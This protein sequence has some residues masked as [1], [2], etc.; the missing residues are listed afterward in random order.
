[1][2]NRYGNEYWFE[3]VEHNVYRV[4][5]DLKFWR[6]GGREGQSGIDLEDLGF[7]DPSG[8]PFI[9]TGYTIQDREHNRKVVKISAE[10]DP[11]DDNK[12][13]VLL[14]VE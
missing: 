6:F 5:G 14:T 8:G 9:S 11:I 4:C 1:M 13:I 12:A 10:I 3:P 7:C 2:K